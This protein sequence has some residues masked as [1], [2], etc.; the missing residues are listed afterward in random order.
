MMTI[1]NIVLVVWKVLRIDLENS[2]HRKK[3]IVMCG[4]RCWLNLL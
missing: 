4:V 1:V 3:H 2:H